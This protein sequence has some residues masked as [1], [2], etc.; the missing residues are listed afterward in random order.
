ML[1]VQWETAGRAAQWTDASPH[2]VM[3]QKPSRET[4]TAQSV[5]P[6]ILLGATDASSVAYPGI[7]DLID[8]ALHRCREPLVLSTR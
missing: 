3:A 6:A 1:Q 5:A 2:L 7:F 8:A 4:G